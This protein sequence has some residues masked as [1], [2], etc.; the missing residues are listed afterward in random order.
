MLWAEDESGSF[1]Y[2]SKQGFDIRDIHPVRTVQG[3]HLG[4]GHAACG[5]EAG[6]QAGHHPQEPRELGVRLLVEPPAGGAQE[7]PAG[8]EHGGQLLGATPGHLPAPITLRGSHQC[9]HPDV[10]AHLQGGGQVV[11]TLAAHVLVFGVK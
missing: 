5:W 10:Y 7:V 6:Q 11:P 2:H 1:V 4:G 8:L 3:N 9:Q